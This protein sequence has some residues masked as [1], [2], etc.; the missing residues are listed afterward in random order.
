ME[1]S[2]EPLAFNVAKLHF[3]QCGS[4]TPKESK[5][6]SVLLSCLFTC[7]QTQKSIM[8]Y[9]NSIFFYI[10]HGYKLNC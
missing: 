5:R 1:Y 8:S 9:T 6:W 4:F 10:Q 7:T 2:A 3:P